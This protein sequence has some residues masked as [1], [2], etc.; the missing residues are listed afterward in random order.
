[1]KNKSPLLSDIPLSNYRMDLV[2]D[3]RGYYGWQR[4]KDKRTIQ[5]ALEATITGCFGIRSNVEGSGRTD[6]GT[7]ATGQVATVQ[8]PEELDIAQALTNLNERLGS[9]IEITN[10]Q[11][12]ASDFHARDSAVA[13]RYVYKIWNNPGLPDEL[14]GRVWFVPE[15]LDIT[16][17]KEA[18]PYFVGTLDYGSFA[19]VPNFKRATT[20][21]TVHAFDLMTS[22]DTLLTFSIIA[23]GFLYKMVRN[24][25]RTVTKV[26]EGRIALREI[27]GIIAAKNR[28]AAPGTAP[29]SGLYLDQVYYDREGLQE[30]VAQNHEPERTA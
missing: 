23:D 18:C 22:D 12:V 27:P 8:L 26:G 25:V 16:A 9:G 30:A 7:H 1:M 19:K 3:G 24:L 10:L 5:E 11:S 2:Y 21:R 29:A 14:D 15:K 28:S 17:M 4:L 13:K 6:R 20:E